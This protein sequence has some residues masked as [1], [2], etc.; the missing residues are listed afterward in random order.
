VQVERGGDVELV[1]VKTWDG[2]PVRT[3]EEVRITLEGDAEALVVSVAGAFH[4]DPPPEAP[5]GP[6][7]RLWEHEV[8]EL[9]LVGENDVYTEIELGPHGHHLVLRL[10]GVRTVIEKCLPIE[11]SASIEGDR[12][13]GRARIPRALLPDPVQRMNAYAIHGTGEGRRYL[14]WSPVPGDG[15]DFHRLHLFPRLPR[16]LP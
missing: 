15:P 12:W 6:T 9:F 8:A 2:V 1:V 4:G 3:S 13:R 7:D 14:A 16:A 5:A 11:Y 10:G